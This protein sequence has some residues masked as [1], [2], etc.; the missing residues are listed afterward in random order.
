MA[1]G[2]LLLLD[3]IATI[4]DD[5][6]LMSKMAAKKTAG[7]LGDDLALN[8]QQ[9][10]GVRSDRELPIVWKVA[11]GSFVNKLILVPL[12]LLISV[13][14]PWL[15][16]PLLML[17]GLFLCYEGVEKV[18]HTFMHKKASTSEE[19]KAELENEEL[20]LA[21]FE[22]EK[23]KGAVRTDFILSAEIVVIT[24]GTVATATL[25]TKVSVLSVIAIVMTIGV[26]GLVGMIVKID[27]L[28]LY[29]T[30]QST[31]FKQTIGRG[32]LA[33]API[34]M[35]LLSIVGTI[36]MF[37]VGGGI[38]NH[39]IP[40]LHH[41]TEN[42]VDHVETIPAVGNIIGALTPTLINF[43]IGLVA[44]AIVLLIVSL[45]QKMWPKK[46]SGS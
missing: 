28:G 23:I 33:F 42:T 7:V 46:A 22:K 20:D 44:G 4:L 9:V 10:T 27:D 19:A 32:L 39:T 18:L 30:E 31:S 43:G 14:A 40:L 35:K 29:L 25:M 12:A 5:V 26:Y 45:I 8:A 3:D 6:A 34:L 41:L 36:A 15:I 17:G 38:I 11:K 1:S 16:N 37:L 24:L 13:I 21:T 2:L